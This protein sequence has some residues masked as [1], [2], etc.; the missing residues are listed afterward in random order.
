MGNASQSSDEAN[1][2]LVIKVVVENTI[3]NL[4]RLAD[5]VLYTINLSLVEAIFGCKKE[6]V[7]LEN[8][9]ETVEVK[10]GLQFD[11]KIVF[12]NK[13]GLYR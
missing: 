1:G 12:K 13:V 4:E 6:F 11:E 9:K 5:D 7:T 8:K 3:P 10:P 2:D